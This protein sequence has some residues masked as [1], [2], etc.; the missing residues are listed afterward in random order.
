MK[1]LLLISNSTNPGE[2][3]LGWPQQHIEDF[4]KKFNVKK[5]LFIPYAGINIRPSTVNEDEPFSIRESYD[6]YEKK[7]SAV[8]EKFNIKIQSIHKSKHPIEAIINAEAIAVGGGNTFYL[9]Y[10]LHKLGLMEAIRERILD[11]IPYIGWSAGSNV[12]CP[13]MKTTND[14]P[15]VEP[16]NM[17][18]LNVIPF[19]INPHYTELSITGH[20]GE[21]RRDRILEFLAANRNIYVVGLRERCLLLVENDKLSL[22]GPHPLKVF[23]YGMELDVTD[24][25]GLDFLMK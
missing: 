3:Y 22:I 14:M 6:T 8:Y 4:C 5:V 18:C 15:V 9:V 21:T 24:S 17:N 16:E 13:S 11:G 1:N 10:M 25:Q 2:Q 12:A 19:Q 7:V 20:G 23:K